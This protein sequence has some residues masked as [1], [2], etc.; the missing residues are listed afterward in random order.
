MSEVPVD[1]IYS[2]NIKAID[3]PD[4]VTNIKDY[5]F[6]ECD[7]LTSVTIGDNVKRIGDSAFE[8]CTS[9]TSVTI[10]RGMKIIG[11][12]AFKNCIL[13]KSLIIPD[14]VKKIGKGA[15]EGCSSLEIINYTGT[16]KQWD[17]IWITYPWNGKS[18]IKLIQCIDGSI[19]FHR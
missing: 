5:A 18:A 13:L 16:K 14:S 11:E 17:S 19:K 1:Y 8:D 7:S 9:L 6:W 3:I 2:S 10:G 4:N 15:I 12:D